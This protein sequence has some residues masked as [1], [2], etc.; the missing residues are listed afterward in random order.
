MLLL[1]AIVLCLG[2]VPPDEN[3]LPLHLA[4]SFERQ[5]KK[6]PLDGVPVEKPGQQTPGKPAPQKQEPFD[7]P[8]APRDDGSLIVNFGIHGRVSIPFGA[9]DRSYTTYYGYYFV[10][11]YLSWADF[12]NPGWGF[13]VEADFFFGK[14]GPGHRRQP[15]FNYGLAL[16][17]QTDT[18][19]GRRIND[20][21]GASL[22][23]DD[24]TA[25]TIQV[26]GVVL[27]TLGNDFYY[28]GLIALGAIHYSEVGGT[29]SGPFTA[30]K[31]TVFRDTWTFASTFRANG[32]VRLG[33]VG[34]TIGMALRINAPPSEGGRLSMNS[35]AFWTFDVDLGA[36]IGF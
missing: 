30:F 32:G 27:Q 14:N 31:D 8:P 10:D 15:G 35:G 13:E 36:E 25:N 2:L 34:L 20:D 26:G 33:P 24:M 28:G 3:E 21:F 19:D 9:A 6:D 1:P 29:F 12:F 5:D 7:A 11:H 18:Y 16:L 23:V 22:S 17:A 4:D